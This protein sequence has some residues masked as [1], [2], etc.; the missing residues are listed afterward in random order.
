MKRVRIAP[1]AAGLLASAVAALLSAQEAARTVPDSSRLTEPGERRVNAIQPPELIM[2]MLGLRPGF[3]V[4]EVGAG[5]GRVTVH[6][7]ARVGDSGK[8]YANDIDPAAV[9]YLG[10]RCRRCG[11]T[12][13]KTILSLPDDARFPRNSL[14][15]ALMTWVYHHVDSPV[16]L[17]RSLLAGLKPWGI[18]VLVEPKPERAESSARALTRSS[19][20]EDARQ[21]GFSLESVIED[22]LTEDNVFVLRPL[23][24]DAP[25]SHDR[26]EVR[27]LWLEYLEWTGTAPGRSSLRD[28][29]L[30]LE[31]KGVP[32]P[33]IGRRLNVLRGQSTEQPEGIERIYDSQYGKPLTGVLEQDGFKTAPNAFLVEA[34]KKIPPGGQALDVGAGMGRNAIHLASLGWEV[35]GIDLS[36]RGL[37]VMQADADKAGLRVQTVKTSYEDFDF[38]REKWDLVAMILSWA[39]VEEPDFLA[40]LKGSI[41][42]GG[43]ILFEHVIQRTSN[44]FPPGVHAL[45]P[46][47]LR[48]LFRDFEILAYRE[49]DHAGD[50][51]GPPAPHVW[52]VA[53]KRV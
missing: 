39:P 4:G 52:L 31:A 5:R 26:H 3:V 12:N 43:H 41:R 18:V 13:V 37:A 9:E 16:P 27:A 38:G 24:P 40:R 29:G 25:E 51:G 30:T 6:I 19:V 49:D 36:A 46:G 21:A 8:V 15:L 20:D 50:W 44:P 22:R 33:E 23:V 48:E 11:L 28:Y 1:L 7:A 35:T 45:A 47:E 2:D 14:D 17:L 34:V 32:G 42:P 53:R 10:E